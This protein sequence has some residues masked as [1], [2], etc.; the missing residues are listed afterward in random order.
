MSVFYWTGI[1]WTPLGLKYSLHCLLL[2]VNTAFSAAFVVSVSSHHGCLSLSIVITSSLFSFVHFSPLLKEG[3]TMLTFHLF[4]V[5]S[6]LTLSC[7]RFIFLVLAHHLKNN[8]LSGVHISSL[9]SPL[10]LLYL[11]CDPENNIDFFFCRERTDKS[12]TSLP[13]SLL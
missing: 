7:I 6:A 8:A 1:C 2:S 13:T 12:L 10:S 9:H 3:G 5:H 4:M 11:Y